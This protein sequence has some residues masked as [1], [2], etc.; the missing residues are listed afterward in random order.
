MVEVDATTADQW[1]IGS[2][3]ALRRVKGKDQVEPKV[4]KAKAKGQPKAAGPARDHTIRV[5][6]HK[7]K[8]KER[9]RI[10]VGK[11]SMGKASMGKAMAKGNPKAKAKEDGL[12]I[13]MNNGTHKDTTTMMGIIGKMGR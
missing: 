12:G 13:S 7:T 2:N 5:I 8:A 3:N 6:A 9:G 10:T 4:E 11:A 1:I